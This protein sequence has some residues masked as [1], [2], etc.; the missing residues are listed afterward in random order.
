MSDEKVVLKQ[1]HAP[2]LAELELVKKR[3][4]RNVPEHL[5]VAEVEE[6]RSIEA[7][8]DELIVQMAAFA[9]EVHDNEY[10]AALRRIRAGESVAAVIAKLKAFVA[11]RRRAVLLRASKNE[12]D[13]S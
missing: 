9:N 1:I 2:T 11:E 7:S 13:P 4:A 10:A 6:L 5:I 3:C 12:N 8:V